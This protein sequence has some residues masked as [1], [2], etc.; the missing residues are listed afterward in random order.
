M[1]MKRTV[2]DP[3]GAYCLSNGISDE[4]RDLM[5]D[6]IL[7]KDTLENLYKRLDALEVNPSAIEKVTNDSLPKYN[8]EPIHFILEFD[9]SFPEG[10]IVKY[11]TRF[12]DK[13]GKADIEKVKF[14]MCCISTR[15]FK[16]YKDYYEAGN[17]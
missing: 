3:F 10:C 4:V 11:L 13:A 9:L 1:K 17:G 12:N 15:D 8:W 14:Y 5:K 6:G 16:H 7:R 2:A